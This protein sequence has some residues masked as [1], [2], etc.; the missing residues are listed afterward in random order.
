MQRLWESDFVKHLQGKSMSVEDKRDLKL[1]K[2]SAVAMDGH[3][4]VS[5]PWR[6]NIWIW[7]I[8]GVLQRQACILSK[9]DRRM[10]T[11]FVCPMKKL[12]Q[13][14]CQS[15]MPVKPHS[16]LLKLK[17]G[18]CLIILMQ[19]NRNSGWYLI[20]LHCVKKGPLRWTTARP[21]FSYRISGST[22]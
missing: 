4:P 2:E 15:N 18:T 1:F 7:W 10:I 20:V 14:M 6:R 21:R 12:W 19:R 11:S 22:A 17:Y 16:V 5:L 9:E 8:T 3:S 13:A